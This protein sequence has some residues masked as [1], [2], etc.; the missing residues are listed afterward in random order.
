MTAMRDWLASLGLTVVLLS[1]IAL[2]VYGWVTL[3]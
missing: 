3:W 2:T 1:L